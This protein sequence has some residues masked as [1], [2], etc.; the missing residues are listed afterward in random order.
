VD[1]IMY[2]EGKVYISKDNILKAEI[3]RLYYDIPVGG[4][5]GQ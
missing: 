3:I 1:G 5:R 4:H 2:K